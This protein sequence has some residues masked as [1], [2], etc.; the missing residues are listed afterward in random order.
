MK[1]LDPVYMKFRIHSD[2]KHY[3]VAVKML[4]EGGEKY[5]EEALVI[6]KKHRLYKQALEFYEG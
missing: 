6:I 2:L 5:F 1:S 3:D 4:A